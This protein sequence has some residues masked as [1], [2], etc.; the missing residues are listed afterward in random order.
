MS[1]LYGGVF[2]LDV[3]DLGPDCAMEDSDGKVL[4][5]SDGKVLLFK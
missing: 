5:D 1:E 3:K 2:G 4:L